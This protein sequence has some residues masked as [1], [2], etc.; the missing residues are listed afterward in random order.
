MRLV[1]AG[2]AG[3]VMDVDD[4]SAGSLEARYLLCTSKS[5]TGTIG[6]VRES[7]PRQL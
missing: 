2:V 7:L 1:K 4:L 6:M 3:R 5:V